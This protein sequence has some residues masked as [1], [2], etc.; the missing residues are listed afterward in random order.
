MSS[1]YFPFCICVLFWSSLGSKHIIKFQGSTK[2]KFFIKIF[3]NKIQLDSEI[4]LVV[5]TSTRL[6]QVSELTE[7]VQR[8]ISIINIEKESAFNVVFNVAFILL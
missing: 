6:D 8:P 5:D 4:V 2:N 3:D 1:S 7:R